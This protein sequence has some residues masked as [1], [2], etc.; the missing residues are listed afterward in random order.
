MSAEVL[1]LSSTGLEEVLLAP[2]HSVPGPF[3][4]LPVIPISDEAEYCKVIRELLQDAEVCSVD[5]E[6]WSV[7]KIIQ[8]PYVEVMVHTNP[9]DCG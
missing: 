5:G 4:V 2:D 6:L 9:Q 8:Y 3:S 1:G 7:C